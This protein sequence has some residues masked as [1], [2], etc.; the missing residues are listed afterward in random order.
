LRSIDSERKETEI[1]SDTVTLRID[2]SLLVELHNESKDKS[3]SFTELKNKIVDFISKD[4]ERLANIIP[5]IKKLPSLDIAVCPEEEVFIASNEQTMA[6]PCQ[7]L[8]GGV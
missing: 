7:K 4:S 2:H 5:S 6:A 3:E 1:R 8:I